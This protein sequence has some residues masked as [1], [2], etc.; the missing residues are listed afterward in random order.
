MKPKGST[1]KR[2]TCKKDHKHGNKCPASWWA[3]VIYI[4]PETGK[5]HDLS[6]RATSYANAIDKRDQLVAE[7]E[8][9]NGRSIGT[10]R[11]TFADL[12]DYYEKKYLKEAEYVDG[13]KVSGLRSLATVKVQLQ[14]LRDHFGSRYL[15]SLTY[16]AIRDFRNARKKPRP[17]PTGNGQLRQ[18]I[19]SLPYCVG[20]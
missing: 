16:G 20:C 4:D 11:M 1:I 14:T 17:E 10:E 12:C 5:T 9:T 2:W 8:A 15:R 3:R 19:A 13:R 7:I 6:R 18:S